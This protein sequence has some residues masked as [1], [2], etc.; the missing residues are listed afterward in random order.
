MTSGQTEFQALSWC[1]KSLGFWIAWVGKQESYSLINNAGFS[2]IGGRFCTS[3]ISWL[4]PLY[5]RRPIKMLSESWR[6]RSTWFHTSRS[7]SVGCASKTQTRVRLF[8]AGSGRF[9]WQR[10]SSLPLHIKDEP[11][12]HW[13]RFTTALDLMRNGCSVGGACVLSVNVPWSDDASLQETELSAQQPE[14]GNIQSTFSTSHCRFQ[15]Q[16]IKKAEL[17]AR[18]ALLQ[19]ERLHGAGC[20]DSCCC[21]NIRD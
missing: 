19:T 4:A 2:C 15:F 13:S 10:W 14:T 9:P 3:L 5:S 12:G 7:S 21:G 20:G 11:S 16:R 8:C 6:T 1:L 17:W 18:W